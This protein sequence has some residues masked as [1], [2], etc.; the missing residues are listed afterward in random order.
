MFVRLTEKSEPID[1]TSDEF[2]NQVKAGKITI[3]SL[4]KNEFIADGQWVT[5]DNYN[6]FHKASPISYPVG[7]HFPELKLKVKRTERELKELKEQEDTLRKWYEKKIEEYL[8]LTPTKTLFDTSS[9][10]SVIS[11][12]TIMPSF[13][14]EI[15]I[16]LLFGSKFI[17]VEVI[18]GN[19]SIWYAESQK[20]IDLNKVRKSS[21]L[22]E[23][24]S[25]KNPEHFISIAKKAVS[26]STS[27]LDGVGYRHEVISKEVNID[28]KY[29][30]PDNQ[31]HP[32]QIKIISLYYNIVKPDYAHWTGCAIFD[33]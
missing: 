30:N 23:I 19:T 14:P 11:R 22:R 16:T 32:E 2:I 31:Q 6:P 3:R 27:T 12:L 28:Y 20:E 9:D 25:F 29:S 17:N 18:N 10:V 24:N 13:D 1:L 21:Y 7:P 8:E 33:T 15:V 5:A 26:C 4:I